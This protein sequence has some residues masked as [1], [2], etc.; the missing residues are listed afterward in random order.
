MSVNLSIS[1]ISMY[2]TIHIEF[3]GLPSKPGDFC[4]AG[5]VGNV[6]ELNTAMGPSVLHVTQKEDQRKSDGDD[7][8]AQIDIQMTEIETKENNLSCLPGACFY[9]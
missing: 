7:I 9:I 2:K 5:P 8:C 6:E 3:Y 1:I 4:L